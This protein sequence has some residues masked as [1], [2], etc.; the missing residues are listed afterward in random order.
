MTDILGGDG[1]MSSLFTHGEEQLAEFGL[2]RAACS[3]CERPT[4]RPRRQL[5]DF[6]TDDHTRS[7]IYGADD[8]LV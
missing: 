8:P 3:P 7:T 5:L 6:L 2:A 4:R 1:L